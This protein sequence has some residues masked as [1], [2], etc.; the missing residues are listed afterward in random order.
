MF[1]EYSLI[2]NS[3]ISLKKSVNKKPEIIKINQKKL[4]TVLDN[5]N[6]KKIDYL[7]IDVEGYEL[8]VLSGFNIKKI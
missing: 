3:K 5:Y 6:I 7:N 1:N 8:K 2:K 4:D